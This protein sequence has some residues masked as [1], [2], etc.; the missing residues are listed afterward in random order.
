MPVVRHLTLNLNPNSPPTHNTPPL[1]GEPNEQQAGVC[2]QAQA[3]DPSSE[4]WHVRPRK[5]DVCIQECQQE[6]R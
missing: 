1:S 3:K 5:D 4:A 6:A 2:V